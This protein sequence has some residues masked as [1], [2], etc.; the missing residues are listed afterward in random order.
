MG[1]GGT[2]ILNGSTT[3]IKGTPAFSIYS[4][5]K[6]AVRNLARSWAMDLKGRG[7]RV[8]IVSPGMVPT[9]GY[10]GLGLTKEQMQG[11]LEAWGGHGPAGA[12]VRQEGGRL[13]VIQ[14]F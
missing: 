11:F 5:T 7:I 10:D 4:S 9:P 2:I 8:N 13:S 12:V 1:E 3:S 6:A 14:R